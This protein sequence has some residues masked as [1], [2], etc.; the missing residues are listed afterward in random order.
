MFYS[1]T[2]LARKGPLGTVW[3]AAHLQHRL[4]KSHYTSTSIPKTVE[5]IMFPEVPLALRMSGHLLLGVVR[6]YSKKVDYLFRDCNVVLTWLAKAFVSTNVDLPEEARKAPVESVTLPE[7]LSLDDFNLDDD[8]F[9]RD[10]NNHLRSHE[11]ITLTDQIPTSTDPY[12]AVTFDED[13]FQ[14]LR[15]MNIDTDTTVPLSGNL[16]NV[17]EET[18]AAM[19]NETEPSNQPGNSNVAQPESF[20]N[21]NGTEEVPD[22]VEFQDSRPSNLTEV[23]NTENTDVNSPQ[24]APEFERM[25][26]ATHDFSPGIHPSIAPKQ[27]NDTDEPTELLDE[28]LNEKENPTPVIAEEMLDLGGHSGFELCSGSPA[29]A[30]REE[31]SANFVLSSPQLALQPS[32]PPAEQQPE[33]RPRK[34]KH[35]DKATVLTNK[36]MKQ[37]LE[38]PSDTLRKKRNMPST[39]LGIWRT[40]KRSR[41]EQMFD[42]PLLTGLSDDLSNCFRQEY[43]ASKPHLAVRDDTVPEQTSVLS[44]TQEAVSEVNPEF[45]TVQSPI[46]ESNVPLSPHSATEAHTDRMVHQSPAQETE[47]VQDFTV[48]LSPHLGS[49]ATVARSAQ[50]F[51]NDDMEIERFRDGAPPEF[52]DSPARF[53]P[54]RTDEF[55][56]QPGTSGMS[57]AMPSYTAE[58]SSC[59]TESEIPGTIPEDFPIPENSELSDIPEIDEELSF[60]EAGSDTPI[61][62]AASRRSGAL[63]VRTR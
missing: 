5:L 60:L 26:D 29:F 6:I 59:R 44:P 42:E 3:C 62:S 35:F 27:R 1:Q 16:D 56:P 34:R 28:T 4:K 20:G 63:S 37:R 11:E 52:L 32:P 38:D 41:K 40:N 53:S 61:K 49:E 58:T 30:V 9:E 7:T 39:S 25:R 43:V 47:A 33:P 54:S 31:E 17:V 18:D 14:D 46:Q 23:L 24:S 51:G 45:T 22:N 36:V 19:P 48:L 10:F 15:P 2:F 57:S 12:V 55:T 13:I 50:S 21:D 8:T